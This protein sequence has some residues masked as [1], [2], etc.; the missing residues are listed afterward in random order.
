MQSARKKSDKE[1]A[2]NLNSLTE[3][4][5]WTCTL[6]ELNV[7]SV[8]LLE[9]NLLILPRICNEPHR[10]HALLICPLCSPFT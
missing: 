9:S 4:R 7:S 10:K 3:H 6:V 8:N 5:K 2:K 1:V